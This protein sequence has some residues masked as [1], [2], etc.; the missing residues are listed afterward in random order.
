MSFRL[1]G[2]QTVLAFITVSVSILVPLSVGRAQTKKSGFNEREIEP[3][4]HAFDKPDNW[5]LTFRFKDPRIISCDVPGRDKKV[6]VWYMLYQIINNTGEPR[7]CSPDIELKTHDYETVHPDESFVMPS[8]MKTIREIEDPTG[9]LDIKN[10]F[11]ISR[12]P[13]PVSKKDAYPRAVNGVA[14]WT[15]VYDRAPKTNRFS[16]FIAGLSDAWQKDAKTEVTRRK[17]LQINFQRLGDDI[18]NDPNAIRW[19]D[20]P[21]WIYRA[22]DVDLIAQDKGKKDAAIVEPVKE[23][24][25][26]KEEPK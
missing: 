1:C 15:D 6:I 22:A 17:T 21:K 19:V 25:K 24:E 4:A 3:E 26:L 5:T 11:T 8:V 14:I 18:Q 16:I 13:I 20:N 2:R 9:K 12:E 10:A 23:K 7:Y